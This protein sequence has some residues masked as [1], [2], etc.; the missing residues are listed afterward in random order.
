MNLVVDYNDGKVIRWG[1]LTMD[2]IKLFDD[3]LKKVKKQLEKGEEKDEIL[4]ANIRQMSKMSVSVFLPDGTVGDAQL[5]HLTIVPPFVE[6]K[7]KEEIITEAKIENKE[8]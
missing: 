5:G 6:L 4:D 7:H 3:Y 1:Y 2:G 8:Q